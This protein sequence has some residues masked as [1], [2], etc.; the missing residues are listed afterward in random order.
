[1]RKVILASSVF[2][3]RKTEHSDLIDLIELCGSVFYPQVSAKS[4]QDEVE[5]TDFSI[6]YVAVAGSEIV[7]CYL[8]KKEPLKTF[9]R[10]ISLE[11]F[12][13]YNNKRGVHVLLWVVAEAW[14]SKG[15]GKALRS[16]SL[17][18]PFDYL[19]ATHLSTKANRKQWLD[20]GRRIVGE[21]SQGKYFVTLMD[22]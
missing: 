13:V 6:S 10:M 21:D 17:K 3:L 16:L 19:W 14:R 8:L 11:D 1:M 7:G 9:P 18:L 2:K 4:I 20:F 5:S 15:V 12:S 22:L